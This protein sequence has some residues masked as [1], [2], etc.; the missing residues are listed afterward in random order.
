MSCCCGY[1][2]GKHVVC[3][4]T[5]LSLPH[6]FLLFTATS[7]QCCSP[8]PLA[9]LLLPRPHTP[10]CSTSSSSLLICFLQLFALFGSLYAAHPAS[11]SSSPPHARAHSY[12]A[13]ALFDFILPRL[14]FCYIFFCVLFSGLF[15]Y[16]VVC[17]VF[18]VY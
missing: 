18:G 8:P 4:N 7:L 10:K 17:S 5:A 1:I 14:L 3:H 6:S 16:S 13:S 12:F 11:F 9:I 2:Y 15:L